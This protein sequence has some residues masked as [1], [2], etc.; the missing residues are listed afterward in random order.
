MFYQPVNPQVVLI[1]KF[2]KED[3]KFYARIFLPFVI[4]ML[5]FPVIYLIPRILSPDAD[6]KA[7]LIRRAEY[8]LMTITNSRDSKS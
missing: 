8:H 6:I 7:V 1:Q 5:V 3:F 4:F 2:D